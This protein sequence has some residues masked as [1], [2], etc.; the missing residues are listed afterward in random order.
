MFFTSVKLADIAAVMGTVPDSLEVEVG[1]TSCQSKLQDMD[2]E[3]A[4]AGDDVVEELVDTRED[5]EQIQRED[6]TLE[7]GQRVV[8][9]WE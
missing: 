2:I 6:D 7:E 1:N 9:D 4:E 5:P 8:L 3:T